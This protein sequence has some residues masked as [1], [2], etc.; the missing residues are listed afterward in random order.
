MLFSAPTNIP[1]QNGLSALTRQLSERGGYGG[2][3]TS[4]LGAQGEKQN[5]LLLRTAQ[6]VGLKPV[7][8]LFQ[9]AFR[10]KIKENH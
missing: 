10:V 6:G 2:D 8:G 1:E 9:A 5:T 3:S 4:G 7:L